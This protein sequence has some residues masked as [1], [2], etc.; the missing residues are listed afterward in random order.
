MDKDE[1]SPESHTKSYSP[2][3]STATSQTPSL[4]SST[5]TI[6][7]D[8]LNKSPENQPFGA[9]FASMYHLL[10]PPKSP[11]TGS[12]SRSPSTCSSAEDYYRGHN[13]S[14]DAIATEQRLN[15]ARLILEYHQLRDQYE[16][17]RADLHDLMEEFHSLRRENADLRKANTELVKF[18]SSQAAVQK[19]LL[20]SGYNNASLLNDLHRLSVRGVSAADEVSDVSPTSVIE[21]RFDKRNPDRISLP[22]SISI[23]S[24]GYPKANQSQTRVNPGGPHVTSH[25]ASESHRVYVPAG[26]TVSKKEEA[27]VELEAYNQGMFKTELCNKWQQTGTCPYANNCQ[28]AH[29]ITELRPVIRHPRYKTEVCR[30]VLAGDTCP[31]GHRCHFRHSLTDQER[32][33]VAQA[34]H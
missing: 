30:M 13:I 23:R 31:Y 3:S 4:L 34:H 1:Q 26:V 17:C 33:S 5:D 20:S 24:G 32:S 2:N 19:L 15:Q 27:A 18:L 7:S 22:K 10:F 8:F 25:T 16:L 11:L 28:F 6:R 21:N 14:S 9:N 29:G 12:L